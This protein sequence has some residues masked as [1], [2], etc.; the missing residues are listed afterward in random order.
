MHKI[1]EAMMQFARHTSRLEGIWEGF[2]SWKKG[3]A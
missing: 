2:I 3:N 1:H